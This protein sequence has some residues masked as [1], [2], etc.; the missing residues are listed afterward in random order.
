MP[1]RRHVYED[2]KCHVCLGKCRHRRN[3]DG[4]SLIEVPKVQGAGLPDSDWVHRYG[5]LSGLDPILRGQFESVSTSSSAARGKRAI[6]PQV[7]RKPPSR[8]TH[9]KARLSNCVGARRKGAGPSPVLGVC[10]PVTSATACDGERLRDGLRSRSPPP[11]HAAPRSGR[12]RTDTPP[13]PLT[14][15]EGAPSCR[16]CPAS[17]APT[18]LEEPADGQ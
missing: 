13:F 16:A 5:C 10:R 14:S 12:L 18:R 3:L 15:A 7:G 1:R 8:M 17:L 6:G 11:P 9:A 4:V 2:G